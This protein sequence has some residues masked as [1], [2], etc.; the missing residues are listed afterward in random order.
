M[1]DNGMMNILKEY[2]L[3]THTKDES[4]KLLSNNNSNTIQ[5]CI[6]NK[7]SVNYTGKVYRYELDK[8]SIGGIT[9]DDL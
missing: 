3:D 8:D 6:R 5:A 4:L 2:K 9:Y 7:N 1:G